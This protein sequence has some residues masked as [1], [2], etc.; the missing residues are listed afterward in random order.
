V[1]FVKIDKSFVQQLP[2]STMDRQLVESVLMIARQLKLQTVAEG[3]ENEAQWQLLHDLGCDSFQ[4][5]LF[6]KPLTGYA[7]ADLMRTGLAHS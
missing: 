6:A 3:V 7:M 1:H 2:D 5:Y 4:G